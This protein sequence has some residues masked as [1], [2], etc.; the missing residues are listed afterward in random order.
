MLASLICAI[1]RTPGPFSTKMP[2]IMCEA[3]A[4][5]MSTCSSFNRSSPVRY[6][7]SEQTTI[8]VFGPRLAS[9]SPTS[10]SCHDQYAATASL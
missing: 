8:V 3:S 6:P 7:W 5:S 2:S 10:P 1:G 9:S 4:S